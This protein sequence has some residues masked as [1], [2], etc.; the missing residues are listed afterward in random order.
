MR[1]RIGDTAIKPELALEI[2]QQLI[3]IRTNLTE[4]YEMDA[5]KYIASVMPDNIR[6]TVIDHGDNRGS[7][8]GEI[9]GTA[10]D[11]KV[12]IFSYLDT[13]KNIG[14]AQWEHAPFAADVEDGVVYGKGAANMKG[15][16]TANVL[17]M[18]ALAHS[19]QPPVSVMMCLT[20]GG[21]ENGIGAA[22]IAEKGYMHGT[23]EAIFTHATGGKIGILQKGAVWTKVSVTG[24]TSFSATP[25]GG[26]NAVEALMEFCIRLRKNIAGRR[27]GRYSQYGRPSCTVT[28]FDSGSGEVNQIPSY[29]E[30]TIDIRFMPYQDSNE[31]I[32]IHN[33]IA[34]ALMADCD[35][36]DINIEVLKIQNSVYMPENSEMVNRFARALASKKAT[37]TGLNIFGDAGYIIPRTG[38]PFIIYGPGEYISAVNEKISIKSILSAA[39]VYVRYIETYRY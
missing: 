3:R 24:K 37:F 20:A 5:V 15:G 36:I 31:I 32:K 11:R 33:E 19:P 8:I 7:L 1:K 27:S 22:E 21:T 13:V 14:M 23:T 10:S 28:S 34:S 6:L 39:E 25:A 12:A 38:I 9:K 18:I 30:A 4:G 17:A 26:V 2:L 29:A 35:D 16:V